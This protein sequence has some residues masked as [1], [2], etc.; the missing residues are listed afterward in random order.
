MTAEAACPRGI[1]K[2]GQGGARLIDVARGEI[3][4][5]GVQRGPGGV[6]GGTGDA[7]GISDGPVVAHAC[8]A[9]CQRLSD[10]VLDVQ[11][12]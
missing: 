12:A 10:L 8:L 5:S 4:I 6:I 2:R 7:G 3:H 1:A 11:D 9:Q